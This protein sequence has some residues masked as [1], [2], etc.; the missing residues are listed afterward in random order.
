[1]LSKAGR[2]QLINSTLSSLSTHVMKAF[3]L[4]KCVLENIDWKKKFDH[5][6][7]D[8]K[9]HTINWEKIARPKSLGWLGIRKDEHQNKFFLLSLY[10]KFYS[11]PQNLWSKIIMNKYGK[12]F[13]NNRRVSSH[14]YKNLMRIQPL[15][16]K[17]TK[18]NIGNGNET[19]VE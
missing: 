16:Q 13:S 4:P 15:F 12:G 2:T 7:E 3:N 1:M 6:G 14:T 5:S 19:I 17:C 11:S 18:F 10:W 9:L 8:R